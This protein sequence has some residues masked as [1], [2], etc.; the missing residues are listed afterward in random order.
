M[1]A[2]SPQKKILCLMISVQRFIVTLKNVLQGREIKGENVM[3]KL[4][5]GRKNTRRSSRGGVD[6]VAAIALGAVERLVGALQN[7][8]H[9]IG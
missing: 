4:L 6:A 9:R 5:A 1:A 7:R 8:F 3:R 2:P